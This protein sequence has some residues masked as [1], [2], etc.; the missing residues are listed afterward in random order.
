MQ[1]P[2]EPS[3]PT[4]HS[5]LAVWLGNAA[6]D[7]LLVEAALPYKPG[8][9]CPGRSGS[10]DDMDYP[11][12][13][14]SAQ[15]LRPW[16]VTFAAIAL[17]SEDDNPKNILSALRPAGIRAEEGMFRATGG[18]NTHKGAIFALGLL[19]ACSALVVAGHPA[20]AR[21]DESLELSEAIRALVAVMSGGIIAAELS[22]ERKLQ[23]TNPRESAGERLYR[24]LGARGARGQAEAGYPIVGT[25]VLPVL[26]RA[27]AVSS[28]VSAAGREAALVEA[29]LGAMAELEDTCV[30]SR[31]ELAGLEFVRSG[32]RMVLEH[33][34]LAT[35]AGRAALEAFDVELTARGLSPGGSADLLAAGIFL[36]VV[37]AEH[38]PSN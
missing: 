29:L 22:A 19:T 21:P 25:R 36:D 17:A 30:L 16:F 20:S 1:S 8:L 9:V 35:E 15:A 14:A 24:Q 38:C 5:N 33:G 6:A 18:V 2:L 12:M 26:R 34:A 10:H 11:L 32:A 3:I 31:G 7:A 13:V 4:S 37:E 27:R 23:G 28:S